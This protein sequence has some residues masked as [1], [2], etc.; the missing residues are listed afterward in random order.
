MVRVAPV[1]VAAKLLLLVN[2]KALLAL[3]SKMLAAPMEMSDVLSIE[4]AAPNAM[5]P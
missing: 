1:L 5:V 3:T 4:P 2:A